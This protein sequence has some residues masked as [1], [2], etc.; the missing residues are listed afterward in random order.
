MKYSL[1]I[2]LASALCLGA[3]DEPEDGFGEKVEQRVKR[4]DSNEYIS[5]GTAREQ[6]QAVM[7]DWLKAN[8]DAAEGGGGC[9][10][11]KSSTSGGYWLVG[12]CCDD[13]DDSSTCTTHYRSF[14]VNNA[15]CT[16]NTL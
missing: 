15:G 11:S 6:G 4:D 8:P 3:C 7:N 5:P 14:C 16:G 13:L 9:E 1:F 10:M 12:K 2:V